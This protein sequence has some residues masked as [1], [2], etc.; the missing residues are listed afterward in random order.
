MTEAIM[1]VRSGVEANGGTFSGDEQQGNFRASG[2]AGQYNV[3][4]RVNVRISEKPV[5]IPNSL[6]EREVRSF[7]SGR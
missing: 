4:D 3:A 6:I 2:I 5:I 1:S 7:F